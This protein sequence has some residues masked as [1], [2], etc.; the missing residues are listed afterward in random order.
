MNCKKLIKNITFLFIL[1]L[2]LFSCNK[3]SVLK[4][5]FNC[6]ESYFS[7]LKVIAD[8]KAKFSVEFPN[9]WKTNLYTDEIQSSIYGA[10]TTKQLTETILLDVSYISNAIQI[11]D[12]FKLK[13][14]TDNLLN[15]LVQIKSKELTFLNKPSYYAVSMGK[16]GNFNYKYLQ[17]FVSLDAENLLII[18]AEIYGDSLVNNRLCKAITLIDIIIIHQ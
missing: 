13:I 11:D 4:Q 12:S 15:K 1:A 8:V 5:N 18:K 7:N 10:D 3:E 14:E 9:N 6:K 16:K 17:F 2:I